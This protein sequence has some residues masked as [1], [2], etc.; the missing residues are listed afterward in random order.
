ML[1]VRSKADMAR[2]DVPR[3]VLLRILFHRARRVAG[4]W[5]EIEL[6]ALRKKVLLWNRAISACEAVH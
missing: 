5:R 4:R 6:D 3:E 2:G 1:T